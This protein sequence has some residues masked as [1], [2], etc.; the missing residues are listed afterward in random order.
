[1]NFCLGGA[2]SGMIFR[3][4]W[5]QQVTLIDKLIRLI[6]V[7]PYRGASSSSSFL[8]GDELRHKWG[9]YWSWQPSRSIK[10]PPLTAQASAGWAV[11]PCAG[12]CVNVNSFL[13]TLGSDNQIEMRIL[14]FGRALLL[15]AQRW[16][17][18]WEWD[19]TCHCLHLSGSSFI[20]FAVL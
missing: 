1:M 12:M 5:Y 8:C 20:K 14:S 3:F 4:S 15:T 2:Y 17:R 16:K 10:A 18:G 13:I 6:G 19:T 9:K 7:C 11:E